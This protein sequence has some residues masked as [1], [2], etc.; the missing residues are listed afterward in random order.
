[1]N[2]KSKEPGGRLLCS[3]YRDSTNQATRI[4]SIAEVTFVRSISGYLL[5]V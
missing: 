3:L 1:M 2:R 4:H 5:Y